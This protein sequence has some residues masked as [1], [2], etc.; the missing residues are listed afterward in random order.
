MAWSKRGR[1]SSRNP[2]VE[3]DTREFIHQIQNNFLPPLHSG[4]SA[5]EPRWLWL[6]NSNKLMRNMLVPLAKGIFPFLLLAVSSW[7]FAWTRVLTPRPPSACKRGTPMYHS[8]LKN[9]DNQSG[10]SKCWWSCIWS[11]SFG[12]YQP[13]TSGNKGDR[14]HSSHW[15][16]NAYFYKWHSMRHGYI[17]LI[18]SSMRRFVVILAVNWTLT[19]SLFFRIGTSNV[20]LTW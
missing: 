7:S 6:K 17:M 19:T 20:W 5:T 10:H 15:L 13:K 1:L 8:E 14:G 3:Y 4:H 18:I 12:H 9:S 2:V 11:A 16:R